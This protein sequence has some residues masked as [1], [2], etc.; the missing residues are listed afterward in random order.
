M[1]SFVTFISNAA[2]IGQML[3]ITNIV[4]ISL[5]S[6]IL[7]G[8]VIAA[9]TGI[10]RGFF[11]STFRMLFMLSLVGVA[12]AFLSPTIDAVKSFDIAAFSEKYNLGISLYVNI[13]NA[14]TGIQIYVPVTNVFDTLANTIEALMQAYQVPGAPSEI[15]QTA[16]ALASMIIKYGV[17]LVDM[18][19]IITLGYTLCWILWHLCFKHIVP[20]VVRKLVKIRWLAAIEEVVT[21]VVV[22]GLFIAP[23]TS[24]VNVANQ[25]WQKIEHDPNNELVQNVDKFVNLYN[26]SLF[27]KTFFNWTVND[28]GLTLDAQLIDYVTTTVVGGAEVSL[29]QTLSSLTDIGSLLLN[30]VTDINGNNPI[31]FG[32]LLSEKTLTELFSSINK[33]QLFTYLLPI[34]ATVAMNLDVV[35]E[36]IDPKLIEISDIDWV[37]EINN[38]QTVTID[39]VNSGI[40]DLFLDENGNPIQNNGATPEQTMQQVEQLINKMLSKESYPYFERIISSIDESK[41][42]SRVIPAL[43][44]TVSEGNPSM[45]DILPKTW[46]EM[47][48]FEWGAELNIV[49]NSLFRLKTTAPDVV[50][51]LIKYGF[52]YDSQAVPNGAY[53]PLMAKEGEENKQPSDEIINI[54]TDNLD[55]L[56]S[57]LIGEFDETGELV[58]IDENGYTKVFEN[59]KRIPNRFFT[60]MD[61]NLFS[62]LLP[63]LLKTVVGSLGT[64]ESSFIKPEVIKDALDTLN[65]GKQVKNYKVEFGA[66][67]TAINEVVKN[68]TL[69]DMIL[70]EKKTDPMDLLKDSS[71]VNSVVDLLPIFDRSIIFNGALK[72]FLIDTV[73]QQGEQ[74]ASLGLSVD[75]FNFETKDFTGEIAHLLKAMPTIVYFMD[76]MS[77]NLSESDLFEEIANNSDKIALLLDVVFESDIFNPQENFFDDDLENNFFTVLQAIF[78]SPD[79]EK[80]KIDGMVFDPAK[81]NLDPKTKLPI[82]TTK[83]IHNW[84]NTKNPD[85]SFVKDAWGRPI[86][87][88]ETGYIANIITS[89]GVKSNVPGSIYEGKTLFSAF[90]SGS[91]TE[92]IGYLESDFNISKVF[93]T[94]DD[95]TLFSTMFGPFLDSLLDDPSIGIVDHSQNQGFSYVKSWTEEGK[96]FARVC[97]AIKNAEIDLANLDISTFNAD[98][99]PHLNSMLH[100]LADSQMFGDDE[101][102]TFNAFL[103]E[104]LHGQLAGSGTDM[105]ADAFTGT[106]T[107]PATYNTA[108]HDFG[109]KTIQ[110]EQGTTTVDKIVNDPTTS[111]GSKAT[112]VSDSWMNEFGSM[113]KAQLEDAAKNNPN[114]YEGDYISSVCKLLVEF[115]N[116]NE[117]INAGAPSSG[118]PDIMGALE[119]KTIESS[120][121]KSLLITMNDIDPFRI[122]LYNAI[123]DASNIKIIDE[124]MGLGRSITLE[125]MN[126]EFFIDDKNFTKQDREDEINRFLEIYDILMKVLDGNEGKE[127]TSLLSDVNNV[128]KLK[129]VITRMNSSY[130]FHLAGY[131]SKDGS[132]TNLYTHTMYQTVL[133]T[134]VMSE[135]I[136]KFFYSAT[137]PKDINAVD[138]NNVDT[139]K[140]AYVLDIY[141]VPTKA[142]R[143]ERIVYQQQETSKILEILSALTG[144]YKDLFNVE[145]KEVVV[146]GVKTE[147]AFR[148][149]SDTPLV[150][151]VVGGVLQNPE[152]FYCG[153]VDKDGN[154]ILDI[155]LLDYDQIKGNAIVDIMNCFNNS[156]LLYDCAPN[157]L[158]EIFNSIKT[159]NTDPNNIFSKALATANPYYIYT[160][161]GETNYNNRFYREDV[162]LAS[163][164]D[165]NEFTNIGEIVDIYLDLSKQ[166]EG[167]KGFSDLLNGGLSLE[168]VNNTIKPL[169]TSMK[170]TFIMHRAAINRLNK[171]EFINKDRTLTS[172]EQIVYGFFDEAKIADMLP[173]ATPASKRETVKNSIR[174][175]SYVDSVNNGKNPFGGLSMNWDDEIDSLF[176]FVLDISKYSGGDIGAFEFNLNN[177]NLSPENV[178]SLLYKFN[179]IDTCDGAMS[180]LFKTILADGSVN[181][182]TYATYNGQDLTNYTLKRLEFG[183]DVPKAG[184]PTNEI[185]TLFNLLNTIS[186]K[187]AQGKH[188]H[189]VSLNGVDITTF[190]K[191]RSSSVLLDFID[192]S[193]LYNN[194]VETKDIKTPVFV[195]SIFFY[196]LFESC[197]LDGF[198][199]GIE[200][201]D[202][203]RVINRL[204]NQIT[205]D[206]GTR[207][208]DSVNEARTLD[209]L[210]TE[211]SIITDN[212]KFDPSN[213]ESVRTIV[214]TINKFIVSLSNTFEQTTPDGP[215]TNVQP[216]GR[217]FISSEVIANILQDLIDEQ[218]RNIRT[219]QL[220]GNRFNET[221]LK[222]FRANKD[223]GRVQQNA[224][225]KATWYQ[226]INAHSYDLLNKHEADGLCTILNLYDPSIPAQDYLTTLTKD[227]LKDT[228][229]TDETGTHNSYIAT[230][231]YL[232]NIYYLF[233]K[234]DGT[235]LLKDN[236]NE[237]LTIQTKLNGIAI[238]DI[239]FPPSHPAYE[240]LAKQREQLIK[241][242]NKAKA[243]CQA[244]IYG[245]PLLGINDLFEYDGKGNGVSLLDHADMIEQYPNLLAQ[246]TKDL[247]P[248]AKYLS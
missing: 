80:G 158:N 94:I 84:T 12:L 152:D 74:F 130:L 81:L 57:V 114:F 176:D 186:E 169:L 219:Y 59:G 222:F 146:D 47:N 103:Y 46:E 7:A 60:L 133:S 144:G 119:A 18:I 11:S 79:G 194:I 32:Y 236:K 240:S 42:L 66:L 174:Q 109:V 65:S 54:L 51:L 26:D 53:G 110:I 29:T 154:P 243:S 68:A 190:I 93:A 138:Y 39:L 123:D 202:K 121:L 161:D 8:V 102:F 165:A 2:D 145:I 191:E 69:K 95:S 143:D 111:S 88:G 171:D 17:L 58:G 19:L 211:S 173:G 221:N 131:A 220:D 233:D 228:V 98:T 16:W 198:I 14:E 28:Q 226:E 208:Y 203:I 56:V 184:E 87:D 227:K 148:K 150:K 189:Y 182:A 22:G 134:F 195:K 100:S 215:L 247:E 205:N 36:V 13:A 137:S 223:G 136:E 206:D 139:K 72:P 97:D 155:G 45:A 107:V 209:L 70:G 124:S 135:S 126:S 106:A 75:S 27:A 164:P 120:D 230:V 116:I 20:L 99:M 149:G 147:Q 239:P 31:N 73:K 246:L 132:E 6:A 234:P 122:V 185:N 90:T 35:R 242:I 245:I 85:G 21:Y 129:D 192:D 15:A 177:P 52:D 188:D 241:D 77:S 71:V 91:P 238:P 216:A 113:N 61:S 118:I 43:L 49:Y 41:L 63:N 92:A 248:L 235:G 86:F 40:L 10:V 231:I 82:S 9:V 199:S 167:G 64:G 5:F 168:L 4:L 55:E 210:I 232:N 170:D 105:L 83:G 200:A 193:Y 112:W 142:E 153:I 180:E 108:M 33:S 166:L 204:M 244:A 101:R 156:D 237:L 178:Q 24:I 196:N 96:N 213:I 197:H 89:L 187:D 67:F 23:L 25:S 214:S 181:F 218:T 179:R 76:L 160:L 225:N 207:A 162:D 229:Y 151:K 37:N 217:S 44:M 224:E 159:G 48:S 62:Y 115:S 104:K 201:D 117:K 141:N 50:D 172:Y 175:L 38:V 157:V 212:S 30:S 128:V 78:G 34:A 125:E 163:R 140:D 183:V 3:E 127:I 1:S